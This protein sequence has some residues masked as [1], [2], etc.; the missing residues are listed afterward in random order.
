MDAIRN[1]EIYG[2]FNE[3]MVLL[4]VSFLKLQNKKETFG[5]LKLTLSHLIEIF[6]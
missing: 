4:T 3:N 5:Y 1:M 2:L 6:S